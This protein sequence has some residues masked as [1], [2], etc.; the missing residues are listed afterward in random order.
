MLLDFMGGACPMPSIIRLR[1][2]E[3]TALQ[4]LALDAQPQH[5]GR[6]TCA[7]IILAL[8]A[9]WSNSLVARRLGVRRNT[10]AAWR[11]S[12]GRE[13][14]KCFDRPVSRQLG[15][16]REQEFFEVLSTLSQV[17]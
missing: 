9:G 11:E 13:R 15:R 16:G 4:E 8:D 17:G 2:K 6:A 12:F 3:S 5:R 14:L 1:A 10:V 7:V